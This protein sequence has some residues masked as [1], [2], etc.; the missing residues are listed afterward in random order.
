MV[1]SWYYKF[2]IVRCNTFIVISWPFQW[3]HHFPAFVY[4]GEANVKVRSM[5][6]DAFALTRRVLC[7]N[8]KPFLD[9]CTTWKADMCMVAITSTNT[10]PLLAAFIPY[11]MHSLSARFIRLVLCILFY[12][13]E[14]RLLPRSRVE[15][16]ER[17]QEGWF[18]ETWSL[19]IFFLLRQS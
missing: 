9:T 17:P 11:F 4:V 14:K 18:H 10:K 19:F 3:P 16:C 7:E 12:E 2:N 8:V 13:A 15:L 5:K 6:F 1:C